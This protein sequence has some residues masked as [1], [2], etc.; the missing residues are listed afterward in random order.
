VTAD[1]RQKLNALGRAHK[2]TAFIFLR[3]CVVVADLGHCQFMPGVPGA[4]ENELQFAAMQV[5]VEIGCYG[6]L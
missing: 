6:E 2:H 3:E 5:V 4:M 1:V